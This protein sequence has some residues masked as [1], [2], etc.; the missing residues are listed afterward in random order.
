MTDHFDDEDAA[1]GLPSVDKTYRPYG[2]E[3]GNVYVTGAGLFPTAG[4]WN[5][6][7]HLS[8][9]T[10]APILI[11]ITLATPTIV[12]FAQHLAKTLVMPPKRVGVCTPDQLGMPRMIY[13]VI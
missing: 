4:S 8:I 9:T 5:R 13:A 12:G 11:R 6:M 10:P 2:L 1:I 7:L 3:K